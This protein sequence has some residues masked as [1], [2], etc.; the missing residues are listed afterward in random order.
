MAMRSGRILRRSFRGPCVTGAARAFLVAL[1]VAITYT[2]TARAAATLQVTGLSF[3]SG[4][5][6]SSPPTTI[7]VTLSG[8]C[9]PSAINANTV[10][11]VRAGPDGILGTA[12]DATIT[13][14][15]LSLSNNN[16]QINIDLTD[17]KQPND[18]YQLKLRGVESLL[19]FN[20][21]QHVA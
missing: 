11:L 1:F 16:T 9:D 19:H 18:Q 12:D 10:Q 20:G 13:P 3:T 4:D 2:G 5:T 21:S 17:V 15:A 7:A 6:L 14:N 8:P